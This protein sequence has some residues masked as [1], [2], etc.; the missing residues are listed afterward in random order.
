MNTLQLCGGAALMIPIHPSP[1]V[2][3][4]S[5]SSRERVLLSQYNNNVPIMSDDYN[6]NNMKGDVPFRSVNDHA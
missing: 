5:D 4:N 1:L 6:N 2:R 3:R